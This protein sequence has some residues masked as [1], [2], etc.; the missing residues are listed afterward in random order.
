MTDRGVALDQMLADLEELVNVESPSRQVEPI[1]RSAHAVDALL[2][3]RTGHHATLIDGPNGPHVSW[4]M[5]GVDPTVLIVGHHD[6]VFPLGT[7]DQRPFTVADGRATGPGVFDMKSGIVVAVHAV[8]E[9]IGAGIPLGVEILMTSDEEV[10]STTSRALIEERALACG[11]ALVF[12]PA[13][14]GGALKV[15][16]KGMGTFEVVVRGRAAHAGLEPEKGINSLLA[17]AELIQEIATF[18]DPAHGTTVTPTMASSGTADNVIPA[19]TRVA[20]DARVTMMD[21]HRRVEAAMRALRST[22][23]GAVVEV[24]G[25]INR[26]PMPAESSATLVPIALAAAAAVGSHQLDTVA[27]GGGSDGNL[28]AAVGVPTLDGLGALGGGAHAD[29]EFVEVDALVPRARLVAELLRRL[30]ARQS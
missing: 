1:T 17:A 20:V 9:L 14:D 25:G 16:R 30:L 8:A 28:T 6:T 12:E 2:R 21:E 5:P 24:N 4:T 3:R 11:T 22:V 13:G 19:L 29:H 23:P 15:A 27:V 18:G 10:G 26:P 7:L